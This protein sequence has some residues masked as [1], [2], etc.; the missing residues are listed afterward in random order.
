MMK[1]LQ[2]EV[3]DAKPDMVIWQVGTNAVLRNLDPVT[4]GKLVEEGVGIIQAAGADVVLVDPQYSPAVNAKGESASKMVNL[5]SRSRTTGTSE[6][7]RAS[8]S[9]A[10]G[11]TG[12]RCRS[13]SSS[14]TTVC[15]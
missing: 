15:T 2:S 6:F 14:T 1:R 4:T 13:K 8:R 10:T 7:S 9:C 5:L 11:T 12:N 3:I